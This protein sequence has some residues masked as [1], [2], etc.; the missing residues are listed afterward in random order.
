MLKR[1]SVVVF[2]HVLGM[3]PSDIIKFYATFIFTFNIDLDMIT[4]DDIGLSPE[5]FRFSPK[6]NYVRFVTYI[7]ALE[8]AYS[9]FFDFVL[10]PIIL[11]LLL[12]LLLLPL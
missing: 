7:V 5:R 2:E 4:F 6:K 12:T 1:S 8:Q 10:L 3:S 11:L 9:K